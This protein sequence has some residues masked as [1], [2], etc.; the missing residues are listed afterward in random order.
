MIYVDTSALVKL[1]V[2]EPGSATLVKRIAGRQLISSALARTETLRAVVRLCPEALAGVTG[3]LD[4]VAL[5]A[6]SDSILADAT[7]V[8]PASVRT[9]DAIHLATARQLGDVVDVL[10]SYDLRMLAAAAAW[11][12]AAESPGV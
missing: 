1:A 4:R 8:T 2:A 6:I 3:L 5:V 12:I 11:G 9:L 7:A 10:I